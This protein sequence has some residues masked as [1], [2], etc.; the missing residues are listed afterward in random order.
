MNENVEENGLIEPRNTNKE[1]KASWQKVLSWAT[2]IIAVTMPLVSLGLSIM[3]IASANEEDKKEV[4]IINAV[5]ILIVV[6]MVVNDVVL[7]LFLN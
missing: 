6:T 1:F 7:A 3:C 4:T 5:S 2:L